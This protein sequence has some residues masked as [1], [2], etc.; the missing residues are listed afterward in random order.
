[1]CKQSDKAC[2]YYHSLFDLRKKLGTDFRLFIKILSHLQAV[3]QKQLLCRKMFDSHS[4]IPGGRIAI[5]GL[6]LRDEVL[7]QPTEKTRLRE[8]RMCRRKSKKSLTLTWMHQRQSVQLWPFSLSSENS[9]RKRPDHSLSGG[10][11]FLL[12]LKTQSSTTIHRERK[13]RTRP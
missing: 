3:N 7:E 2:T 1:M 11:C 12:N 6:R 5:F 9:R 13:K 10:A 4:E 8:L